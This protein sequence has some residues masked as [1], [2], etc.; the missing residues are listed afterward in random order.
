MMIFILD[1]LRRYISSVHKKKCSGAKIVKVNIKNLSSISNFISG[2]MLKNDANIWF[3]LLSAS[4]TFLFF[5][6]TRG[7]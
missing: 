3:T 4:K 5:A 7:E 2:T 6:W 1:E